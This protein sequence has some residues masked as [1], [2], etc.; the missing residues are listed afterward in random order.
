MCDKYKIVCAKSGSASEIICILFLNKS[1]T[2][3]YALS[4]PHK[5]K[6]IHH[7]ELQI[8]LFVCTH[9]INKMFWFKK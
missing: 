8:V 5:G 4:F 7:S 1:G 9:N 6:T 3:K 2:F